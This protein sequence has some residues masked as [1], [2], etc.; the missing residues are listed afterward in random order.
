MATVSEFTNQGTPLTETPSNFPCFGNVGPPY[1][2][3]F[4]LPGFVIG[5]LVWLF[6][7]LLASNTPIVPPQRD[8]SPQ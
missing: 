5:L 7:T 8:A 4:S 3:T 6:S 2:A 1:M